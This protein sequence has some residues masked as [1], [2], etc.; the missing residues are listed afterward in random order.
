MNIFDKIKSEMAMMTPGV[1]GIGAVIG[2]AIGWLVF[3]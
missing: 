1:L 2:F 3:P